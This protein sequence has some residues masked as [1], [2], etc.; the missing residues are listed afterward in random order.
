MLIVSLVVA[1][2]L[3]IVQVVSPDG[4]VCADLTLGDGRQEVMPFLSKVPTTWE[5]LRVIAGSP[6]TGDGAVVA[7]RKGD[8]RFAGG[9]CRLEG[10]KAVGGYAVSRRRRLDARGVCRWCER[11]RDSSDCERTVKTVAAGDPVDINLSAG[12]GW[13]GR[14]VRR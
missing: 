8:A 14:F 4:K 3:P 1:A 12:G 10:A 13:V 9:H 6:E 7:R 5:D 2:A 11:A